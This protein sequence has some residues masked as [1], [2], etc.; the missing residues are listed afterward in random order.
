MK[1]LLVYY[2]TPHGFGHAT[3]AAAV[4]AVLERRGWRVHFRTDVPAWLFKVEGLEAEVSP[5]AVDPGLA[6]KDALTVDWPAA[7]LAHEAFGARW[8]RTADAEAAFLKR[9]GAALAASDVGPLALDA[10]RR[11][12][13]PGAALGNFSWD[14]VIAPKAEADPRWEAVRRRQAEAYASA[15]LFIHMPL[16]GDGPAFKARKTVPMVVR[17]PRLSRDEARRALGLAP[18]DVR[19]LVAFSFGGVDGRGAGR[20][21]DDALEDVVFAGYAPP[22]EG[23]RGEWKRLPK[24]APLRHIDLMQAADAVLTKPGYGTY[25]EALAGRVPVLAV[26]RDDFRESAPITAN[27]LRLGRGR[28]VE[29]VD[30]EAGRWGAALRGLL[31]ARDPWTELDTSGAEAAAGHLLRLAS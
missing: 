6:M 3:R 25:S 15:A 31:A 27:L 11:A 29:R 1:P 12:R 18:G 7:L 8:D 9:S 2:V 4:A 20:L 22:P 19:P 10:A 21:V 16:G 26:A 30:W 14:W 5:A 24:H 28:V 13:I 23:F 17:R